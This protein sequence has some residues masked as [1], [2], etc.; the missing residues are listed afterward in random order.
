M[1]APVDRDKVA[2]AVELLDRALT[3]GVVLDRGDVCDAAL[4]L[5]RALHGG[6]WCVMCGGKATETMHGKTYC[7]QDWPAADLMAEPC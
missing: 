4:M 5:H 3:A 7:L 2:E 6:P 1:T